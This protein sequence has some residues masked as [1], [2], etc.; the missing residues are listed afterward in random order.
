[1][2]ITPPQAFERCVL[3]RRVALNLDLKLMDDGG[4]GCVKL[5]QFRVL[6]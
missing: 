3:C 1:M 5:G 2:L 6:S 4:I